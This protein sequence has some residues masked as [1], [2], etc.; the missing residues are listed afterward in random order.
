M[1]ICPLASI[2]KTMW[3]VG[4]DSLPWAYL[5]GNPD[6]INPY[7]QLCIFTCVSVL[8]RSYLTANGGMRVTACLLSN[9]LTNNLL[10]GS[11]DKKETEDWHFLSLSL[12]LSNCV[13]VSL[14]LPF[15]RFYWPFILF[16]LH[17]LFTLV[18]YNCSTKNIHITQ[19][20]WSVVVVSDVTAHVQKK[21]SAHQTLMQH[22]C[23]WLSDPLCTAAWINRSYCCC[24]PFTGISRGLLFCCCW[25]QITLED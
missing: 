14:L 11:R 13:S 3:S 4:N 6:R 23:C 16:W 15:S 7:T 1:D 22:S 24:K 18:I 9:W 20:A 19:M 10:R 25:P 5:H 2:N 8:L 21:H 17:C 12:L